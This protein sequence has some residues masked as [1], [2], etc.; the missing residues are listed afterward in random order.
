[1][2]RDLALI[3]E[4]SV[5]FNDIVAIA[6]KTGKKLIKEIN[7]FDVYENEEQLGKG[8]KSYA[9]SFLFEDPSK[10]LKDKEV[11]K[12]IKQLIDEYE[13]KLGATIRK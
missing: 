3:I 1:V 8:R 12:V 10:T 5:K 6:K 7:L 11:D 2:R 9:V 13:K 4:N